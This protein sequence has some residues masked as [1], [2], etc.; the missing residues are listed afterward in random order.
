[1]FNSSLHVFQTKKGKKKNM[2]RI[3]Q[4]F[5]IYLIVITKM[6]AVAHHRDPLP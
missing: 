5:R 6:G 3:Y 4:P 1:M 2:Q